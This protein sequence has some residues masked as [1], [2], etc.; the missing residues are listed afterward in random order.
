M[1][2]S[3]IQMI[4]LENEIWQQLPFAEL[5]REALISERRIRKGS[6]LDTERA[7]YSLICRFI[8]EAA[9]DLASRGQAT[10][11][12]DLENDYTETLHNVKTQA[13]KNVS[14]QA[15]IISG[16]LMATMFPPHTLQAHL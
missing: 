2:T 7:R 5:V 16:R 4:F 13:E 15:Q 9:L 11:I 10:H 12:E 1:I 8:E 14:L 6:N 3:R